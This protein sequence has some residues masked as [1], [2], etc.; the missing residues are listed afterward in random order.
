MAVFLKN[1]KILL[2]G[3]VVVAVI[4][5]LAIMFMPGNKPISSPG[6][7]LT[8]IESRLKKL[9][10]QVAAINLKNSNLNGLLEKSKQWEDFMAEY[11]KL[12]SGLILRL[13]DVEDKVG[14]AP[15]SKKT[16]SV[17]APM[18]V[19]TVKNNPT[20]STKKVTAEATAANT[21]PTAYYRV[22]KGDT[23][24]SIGLKYGLKPETLRQ[25]NGLEAN[26][27]KLGQKLKIIMP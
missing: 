7:D 8:Q 23:V 16:E 2:G 20:L 6:K 26:N 4:V 18:I 9:E 1:P 19:P 21:K 11:R 24:Y 15:M 5:V 22:K 13:S 25:M 14:L 12:N 17:P 3:A 27:I 10:A